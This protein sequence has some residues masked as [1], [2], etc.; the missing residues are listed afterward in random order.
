MKKGINILLIIVFMV[1]SGRVGAQMITDT[2]NFT[3]AGYTYG[4][5]PITNYPSAKLYYIMKESDLQAK[6]ITPGMT[7]YGLAWYKANATT[8]NAGASAT[9]MLKM[10]S[11]PDTSLLWFYTYLN[12]YLSNANFVNNFL[13]SGFASATQYSSIGGTLSLPASAG[14]MPFLLDQAFVY[15]GGSIAIY[16]D[17][18]ASTTNWYSIPPAFYG[19]GSFGIT[20]IVNLYPFASINSPNA[21]YPSTII[22]HSPAPPA[23][24]GVPVGGTVTSQSVICT[25]D[26]ACLYLNN[27]TAGVG[28]SYQWQSAAIGS[29]V[30]SNIANATSPF[31]SHVFVNPLQYRC[32]V[33]CASSGLFSYSSSYTVQPF[34]F[35]IDSVATVINGATVG[36]SAFLND[37][38]YLNGISW[39]F[40]DG[41]SAGFNPTSHVYTIDST[42]VVRL[43][44]VGGCNKDTAYKTISVGCPAGAN[45]YS[46]ISLQGGNTSVCAGEAVTLTSNFALPTGYTG[47]WQQTNSSMNFVDIAGATSATITV[48]P[49]TSRSYRFVAHC[50]MSGNDKV[51]NPIYITVKPT[52]EAGAIFATHT[53][54]LSYNFYNQGLAGAQNY[55]WNFG[56]GTTSTLLIPTH[57]Y[58]T[59]GNYTVVFTA[60]NTNT[61]C[62]DTA[63]THVNMLSGIETT[64]VGEQLSIY[65]NP[66]KD[67]LYMNVNEVGHFVVVTL[68]EITG[69][70][71][72]N[73][74]E[75]NT[76]DKTIEMVLPK[77]ATG[78]Y[79]LQIT[80]DG[81]Q[82]PPKRLLIE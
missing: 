25:A 52:P 24:S 14:W 8:L 31:Y 56:D 40:G 11:S 47:Q 58:S 23:C 66:A 32:K 2:I 82:L 67:K 29:S 64:K 60:T 42:Y 18:Q 17:W 55:E 74:Y 48:Y 50:A 78:V 65:P 21:Q 51:S 80:I 49:T 22:Y 70:K 20:S 4:S 37:T 73:L 38:T 77:V 28:I 44:V 15:T 34:T 33:S 54:G 13:S 61:G 76:H 1:I 27:C 53:T 7:I 81:H 3:N 57:T 45:Y 12:S 26:S 9:L 30:W 71:L 68:N 63:Q 43:V 39:K 10:K 19:K 72:Q 36:F 5:I 16:S 59:S 35:N 41:D 69:K 75:D 62:K 79:Y 6:G 46:S